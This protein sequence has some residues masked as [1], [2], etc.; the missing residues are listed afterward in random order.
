MKSKPIDTVCV[1]GAGF[2]GQQI[3]LQS[4]IHGQN[5]WIQDISA[6]VLERT[7]KVIASMLDQITPQKKFAAEEKERILGRVRLAQDA[8]EAARD[9][10]LV[11]ENVPENLELKRGILAKFDDL[12]PENTI[13]STNSSAI[14]ASSLEDAT[15]RPDKVLNL[16]FYPPVWSR[17]MVEL[18]GGTVTS[19]DTMNRVKRFARSIGLMPLMVLKE[20]T[21]FIYNRI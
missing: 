8:A 13:L 16:H 12:C 5:V 1:V 14:R 21:G 6:E 19:E 3:A 9:A 2:M 10:D 17:P 11:I 18:M 20:S 4:A 7:P 15:K